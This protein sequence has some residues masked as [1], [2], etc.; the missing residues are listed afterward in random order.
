M[1]WKSLDQVYLQESAGRAVSKLPRQQIIGEDIYN[2]KYKKEDDIE[3]TE[4]NVDADQFAKASRYLK[5]DTSSLNDVIETFKKS[6]IEEQTI[7][8]ILEIVYRYDNPEKF[9]K[10]MENK[11]SVD[12]FTSAKDVIKLINDKYDLQLELIIDLLRYAP[13]TQ[14]VTGRGETFIILFVEGA[15]KGKVGDVKVGDV[16]YETKGSNARIK[17]QKGF[18][19]HY[20]ASK[21]FAKGIEQLIRNSQLEI[22]F[23]NANFSISVGNNGFIDQIANEMVGTGKVSVDDIAK[24]YADSLGQIY[25]NASQEELLQWIRPSLNENGNILPIFKIRYFLFALKYYAE[26]ENFDYLISLGTNPTTKS[27]FGKMSIISTEEIMAM[28]DSVLD[29]IRPDKYPSFL[30]SAGAYG[31]FFSIKPTI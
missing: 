31:P 12:E 27:R 4:V 29:K 6:G 20:S 17:G 2:V 25:L 30:P 1:S 8:Q 28:S 24:L 13:Q 23:S 3:Y 22:D 16:E 10:A 14:P 19:D 7:K 11:M 9:F 21:T 5:T 15:Q 18:G 26:Q